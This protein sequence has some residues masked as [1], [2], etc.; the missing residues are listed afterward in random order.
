[1]QNGITLRNGYGCDLDALTTGTRIGKGLRPDV[2]DNRWHDLLFV[3]CRK[4]H[5][6][7]ANAPN[8]LVFS[9]MTLV[10]VV[11]RYQYDINIAVIV[12]VVC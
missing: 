7:L 10:S 1:M 12:R 3:Q 2:C 8:L 5:C 4:H 9:L 6:G 11:V